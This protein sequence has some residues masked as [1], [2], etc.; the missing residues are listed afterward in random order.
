MKT[1][2]LRIIGWVREFVRQKLHSGNEDL[3]YFITIFL[4]A[5]LFGITIK[6][7]VE[8]T[9]NLT[10]DKLNAYDTFVTEFVLSFRGT[11]L[12][13]FLT[14]VTHLGDRYAYLSITLVLTAFF[15]FKF[16]NWKFSL[17]VVA[18]LL[19]SSLS[20][21]ALKRVIHR[22]RPTLDHLVDVNSLSFPSGHSMSAMAFYG[23]LFYL[24]LRYKMQPWIRILLTVLLVTLVLSIG[25][26]RIYLGVHF[27]SDVAA[28][29]L[30]GI[31]WVTFS[32]VVFNIIDLLRKRRKVKQR[33]AD[34]KTES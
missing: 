16:K 1:R 22:A 18:V 7:F 12:T 8:I 9:E 25:I 23:F 10:E 21:I 32:V 34:P 29:Y 26:S 2:I 27:P 17:Q 6:G 14:F 20:N 5:I 11:F 3:P 30:G 19:L 28:G 13:G 15:W 31:I 4:A 33:A 24:C